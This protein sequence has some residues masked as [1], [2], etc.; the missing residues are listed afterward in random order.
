MRTLSM[1]SAMALMVALGGTMAHAET[2]PAAKNV[3]IVHGALADG[4]GWRGVYDILTK[5]GFHVTIVQEPLTGLDE[6][7][8][9]TKRAIALQ[10]GPVVLVG[11]SYAGLVIGEAGSDPK[12]SALVYVSALVPDVGEAGGQLMQKFAA[13]NDAMAAAKN[14]SN[15]DQFFYMSPAKFAKTY[16][17]DVPEADAEFMANSQVQ[18]GAKAM[19]TPVKV[20]AWH[21]KP[22]YG[23]VTTTDLVVS[24][25]LQAWEYKR[26]GSK[27]TEVAASHAVF[28]SQ[29][30][31]VAKV[32]EQAA[33]AGE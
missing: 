25:K 24:P 3:V 29:P 27:V 1:T 6:D 16:A 4:S 31:L 11:H 9:A 32:I 5:D 26:A 8:E 23:I 2:K 7:V 10:N 20:A 18:L 12:V 17:F 22:S 15:T 13:P 33:K 21:D 19:G 30:A 28:I 14:T